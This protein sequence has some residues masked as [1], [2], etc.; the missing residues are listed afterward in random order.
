MY[1]RVPDDGGIEKAPTPEEVVEGLP[2]KRRRPLLIQIKGWYPIMVLAV[3]LTLLTAG[4]IA[5]TIHLNNDSKDGEARARE[6]LVAAERK[7]DQRWCKL[8]VPLDDSYQ[9]NPNVQA[10]DIGRKVAAA[11]HEIR[12]ETG[13]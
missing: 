2:R 10:T 8:L 7:A 4:N 1:D 3:I 6:S 13:C 11:I 5:Y 9:K 12:I